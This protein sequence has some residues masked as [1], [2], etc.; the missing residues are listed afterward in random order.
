[1]AKK[2]KITKPM[3]E[4]EYIDLVEFTRSC[5]SKSISDMAYAEIEYRMNSSLEKISRKFNIPGLSADDVFQE[6]CYAL[7][8]KAVKDY[9]EERGH[10]GTT[11]A[12]DKFAILCIRRHLS[13]I[14]KSSFQ[15]KRKVLNQS[16]SI[17]QENTNAQNDKSFLHDVLTTNSENIVTDLANVEVYRK[18]I[19]HLYNELSDLEKAVFKLYINRYTYEQIAEYLSTEEGLESINVKGVDNA[20]SR[21]KSKARS[22]RDQYD[23]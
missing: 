3:D 13:T 16:C 6:S 8:Y 1:M 15:N 9:A 19:K 22:I 11:Y 7:R 17:D 4:Y 2:C 14:L 12:F 23:I 21:M 18:F 10:N 20:I 5:S